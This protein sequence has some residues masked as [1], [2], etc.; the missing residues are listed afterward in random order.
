VTVHVLQDEPTS[1][2]DSHGAT[3]LVLMLKVHWVV[4]PRPADECLRALCYSQSG[5]FVVVGAIHLFIRGW[6]RDPSGL[7]SARSTSRRLTC[8]APLTSSCC[9][10]KGASSI[11]ERH[12]ITRPHTPHDTHRTHYTHRMSANMSG[13]QASHVVDYFEKL[14]IRP[15]L[16]TNPADF[17]LDIAFHAR[18]KDLLEGDQHDPH[19]YDY[20]ATA[21]TKPTAEIAGMRSATTSYPAPTSHHSVQGTHRHFHLISLAVANSCAVRVV[22]CRVVCRVPCRAED[23]LQDPAA[24]QAGEDDEEGF[25]IAADEVRRALS[26]NG[27][28]QGL[29]LIGSGAGGDRRS[30]DTRR[31]CPP[32]SSWRIS[33]SSR[34][35]TRASP[36]TWPVNTPTAAANTTYATQSM[37]NATSVAWCT[38]TH[39][40]TVTCVC[41]SPTGEAKPDQDRKVRRF[42]L[43]ADVG[44][45]AQ[46]QPYTHF[47]P[48][49]LF[50]V[51]T[52]DDDDERPGSCCS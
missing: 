41:S 52:D 26:S 29:G 38:C 39:I 36:R 49:Y 6:R 35:P 1:G 31:W 44:P 3:N 33:T 17:I 24:T 16:H 45:L 32:R 42:D 40:L 2:L 34:P 37:D 27:R 22:S 50:G 20:A 47:L 10:P 21:E 18:R 15:P 46:V 8:S 28:G 48:F 14:N 51:L 43:R 11:L 19:H 4:A 5:L 30:A 13:L 25:L 23:Y 9:L 12:A 7:S